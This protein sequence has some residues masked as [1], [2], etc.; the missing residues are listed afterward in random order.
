MSFKGRAY[1]RI[2]KFHSK[3]L[4]PMN[5]P[6]PLV[7]PTPQKPPGAFGVLQSVLTS[8]LTFQA[9]THLG[10]PPTESVILAGGVV[11]LLTSSIHRLAQKWHHEG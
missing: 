1:T 4:A 7:T 9:A 10:L 8:Y 3:D 6:A 5:T 11:S 2:A